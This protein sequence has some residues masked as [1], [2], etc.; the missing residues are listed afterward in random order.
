ME[1]I[2]SVKKIWGGN[3]MDYIILLVLLVGIFYGMKKGLE[4]LEWKIM[5]IS[6]STKE[7]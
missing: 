6:M 4:A 7:N 1:N 2:Y 3:R 5:E